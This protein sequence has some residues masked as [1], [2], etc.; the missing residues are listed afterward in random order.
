METVI[1]NCKCL[2]CRKEF[3]TKQSQFKRGRG[4]YC[5]RICYGKVR[6]EWMKDKDYNP[7]SKMI[8]KGEAN[9]NWRGGKKVICVD[10]DKVLNGRHFRL[11]CAVCNY[12]Y[13]FGDKYYRH[14][15]FD[16]AFRDYPLGWNKTFKEQIRYRDGYK[17]Q[18]CGK[19]EIEEGQRLSIHHIDYNKENINKSNLVS[20]CNA[21]HART[22]HNREYW[23]QYFSEEVMPYAPN[24]DC[25]DL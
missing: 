14:E 2:V 6:S 10:C 13:L 9:P 25:N 22:N 15:N 4:K 12:K 7:F 24:K 18:L 11:R 1:N 23:K 19:P 21:C 8:F 3:Y 5:S 20:V 17:C 16:I